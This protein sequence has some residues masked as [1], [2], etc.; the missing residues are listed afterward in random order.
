MAR[1][2]GKKGNV[3]WIWAVTKPYHGRAILLCVLAVLSNLVALWIAVD[4]KDLINAAVAKDKHLLIVTGIL[5]VALILAQF[6]MKVL[7]RYL[8]DTTSFSITQHLQQKQFAFLLNKDYTYVSEKHSVEW[9][10]RIMLDIDGI[11]AAMTTIL[12]SVIGIAINLIGT[13]YLIYQVTPYLLILVVI[14]GSALVMI[15]YVLKGRL[16]QRQWELRKV[17]G[18]K[19]IYLTEHLS[20]L[21]IVKAFSREA[22][23]E[24]ESRDKFEAMTQKKR[25]KLR[26][27]L[28]KD[29]AQSFAI[30]A[31]YLIVLFYCAIKILLGQISYG[32]SVMFMRLVSQLSSPLTGISGYISQF[33]DIGVSAERLREVETFP[34]DPSGPVKGDEELQAFYE[35]EFRAIVFRDATF[36]Y[37]AQDE[38]YAASVP[39]I[40]SH[41]DI[42]IPK[43]SCMAF[44]GITGSGKSTFFKL[45]MSF[46]NLQSGT[47]AIL[48]NSGEELPL[49]PSFRRLFAYV[50]QGNQLMVGTIREMVTFGIKTTPDMDDEIW[51][52]LDKACA[53]EF[54]EKLPNGLDTVIREKGAGL[55]EGQ[56]QRI[57]I[58]RALY[59]KRPILL[60]DEATSALDEDTEWALLTHLKQMTDRTI[61]FVT[62][63]PN[64]LSICDREV[65]ING[66]KVIM[67]ELTPKQ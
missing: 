32:T 2:K 6:G 43:H 51:E 41:V 48:T 5:M 44:T 19:N 11:A 4:L 59:T 28:C 64:G 17:I 50:P 21:L 30:S 46:Y 16:Q 15:N 1:T 52:V 61:L 22:V 29:G 18:D 14:G 54:V 8:R 57:A 31:A 45:L 35:K 25:E 63:R 24:E 23:I 53:R 47:K 3:Q 36:A 38:E 33:Y 66:T 49:D 42:C 34:D 58:A 27:Q 67:R 62:H 12:P 55:S 65:H 7:T 26:L 20:K 39:R 10:N 40:F 9:L 60:L 37:H 13:G 56:L